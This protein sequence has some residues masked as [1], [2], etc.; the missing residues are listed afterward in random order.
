M[1]ED[2]TLGTNESFD[3]KKI[4]W[5]RLKWLGFIIILGSFSSS[6]LMGVSSLLPIDEEELDQ[7][8]KLL[9]LNALDMEYTTD[10]AEQVFDENITIEE[11]EEM[12]FYKNKEGSIAFEFTGRGHQDSISG[13]VALGPD[14]ESIKGLVIL[15]Q[16]E[17][18]GLGGRIT[19]TEF[20]KQFRSVTLDPDLRIVRGGTAATADNEVEGIT[21]ATRTSQAL[22]EML[23]QSIQEA[24]QVRGLN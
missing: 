2:K 11:F 14:L 1:S 22:E 3:L 5:D 9:I 24:L 20:L 18:P 7:E 21:G 16:A 15:E 8:T 23:N 12:T 19:E 17:T 10:D 4:L 6:M 13:I